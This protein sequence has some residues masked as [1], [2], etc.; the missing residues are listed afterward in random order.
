MEGQKDM[1][2]LNPQNGEPFNKRALIC[3]IVIVLFHLVGLAGLVLPAS[4]QLFLTLVP[5]HILLMLAVVLLSHYRADGSLVLFFALVSVSGFAGE[6]VGVHKAWLF[7]N[8]NYGATLGFKFL[9]IPLIIAVNWFLLVYSAGVIMQRSRVKSITARIICGALLLVLLDLLIEPV[10]VHFDYWHW[11]GNVIP[12][13]NY[14]CWFSLSALLLFIFEKSGFKKQSV[15]APV[16]L[17][18]QFA[19]F[20]VLDVL[21][22]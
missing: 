12:L 8:Y 3:V 18:T 10:A 15:V 13:K 17:L 21:I 19:F 6:W 11:A 2:P 22:R 5:Y 7:G 1:K 4:R 16:L 14:A 20:G 9:G